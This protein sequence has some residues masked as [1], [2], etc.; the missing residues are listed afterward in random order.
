M[1][2][3]RQQQRAKTRAAV[4]RVAAE[5]FDQ[6]GYAAVALSDIAARLDVTKGAV[7]YHFA[8]KATLASAVV[9]T[10]FSAWENL[11]EEVSSQGLRG[12]E[13]LRAL[14]IR[15]AESYRDDVG[16]RAPLR[17]MREADVISIDLPTPFLPWIETVSRHL[18]EAQAAGE[19]R[20]GI[21][22]DGVAWQVV[23]GFFGAQ[24]ISRQLTGSADLVERIAALWDVIL[25][26][27]E[28]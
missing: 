17:L 16:V 10:Y 3:L 2:T 15:V 24:E 25:T 9:D 13:A 21:D 27:I 22:A 19:V 12:I 5:E 6:R 20:Q 1:S 7:Y 28:A 11:V 23:A 14:S 4:I 8:S 18:G 26:G